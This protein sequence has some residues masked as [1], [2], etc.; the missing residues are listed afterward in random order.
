MN[1]ELEN[2]EMGT[3][4][5]IYHEFETWK[6][7]KGDKTIHAKR[8]PGFFRTVKNYTQLCAL[9][10]VLPCALSA[11]E[12]QAGHSV[13]YPESPV[14]LLQPDG[15]AA[16][17][18]DA[19]AGSSDGGDDAVCSDFRGIARLVRLF[20]L[21][22]CLDRLVYL[23]GGQDRGQPGCPAQTGRCAIESGQDQEE[24]VSSMRSGC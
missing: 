3:V 11:L 12:R 7:N 4:T 1:D 21:P 17:H 8:M 19:V 22:D 14:S 5:T 18:L 20:L 10:S 15:V 2:K 24:R 9:A 23:A 6:V 16:G 13:R